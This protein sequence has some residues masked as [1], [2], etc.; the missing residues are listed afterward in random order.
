M[1]KSSAFSR[2]LLRSV[3]VA[4]PLP[5]AGNAQLFV[6]LHPHSHVPEQQLGHFLH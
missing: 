3:F 6:S 1:D 5:F 2:A 4:D